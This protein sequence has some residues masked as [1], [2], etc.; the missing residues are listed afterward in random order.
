VK[1]F[2]L[3]LP[4]VLVCVVSAC[5]GDHKSPASPS[6][7]S[8][9]APLAKPTPDSPAD[10]AQLDNVRPTL[11]VVNATS[12]QSGAKMYEFEISDNSAFSGTASSPGVSEDPSGKTKLTVGQDLQPTTKYYW[13]ARLVQGGSKSD[14]SETRS[15]KTK[16]VGYNKPGALYDPLVNGETVGSIGGSGNITWV[17]GQG[18]RM[19]DE[20]AFVVYQLPQVFSSGE[21]SVEVTGLG[22]DGPPGAGKPRIFSML[23]QQGA[24]A[25]ASRYSFNVQYR[26]AGGAPANCITFKAILGDNAHSLEV[27]NRFANIF[28]LDASTV[29]LWQAFWTPTSFRL[30]VKAGGATGSVVYDEAANATWGTSNWN[31]AQMF[32][33]LGTNN[34]RFVEFDGTRIGMTLRNLWVG[35]MPRPD[36]LGSAI[37]EPHPF[38]RRR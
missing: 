9:P 30:V 2:R 36:T 3:T 35:S 24:I 25:S 6:P 20:L 19:N 37:A 15:F 14:W 21:M 18:I 5:G 27:N 34:G 26:G 1:S 33:F 31:P 12:N 4:L 13:H 29:Y 10:D 23:D 7:T 8:S 16:V 28:R 38:P 11:M 22:P 17:P 32:A